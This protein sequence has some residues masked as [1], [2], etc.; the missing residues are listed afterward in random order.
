MSFSDLGAKIGV[1]SFPATFSPS[2]ERQFA[3]QLIP[4]DLGPRIKA[5][6]QAGHRCSITSRHIKTV[7]TAVPMTGVSLATSSLS[8][9]AMAW[10]ANG[11]WGA[12]RALLQVSSGFLYPARLSCQH[13]QDA[14]VTV[15]AVGA[16]ADGTT[17]PV[18]L[19]GGSVGA[20]TTDDAWTLQSASV[21]SVAITDLQG[22]DLDF[23]FQIRTKGGNSVP[24]PT[25]VGYSQQIPTFTITTGNL[26]LID[27]F[28]AFVGSGDVSFVLRQ[29]ANHGIFGTATITIGGTGVVGVS[30]FGG[31]PSTMAIVVEAEYDGTNNPVTYAYVEGM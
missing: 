20:I 3:G 11:S 9:A 6:M 19:G 25:E 4:G 28:S 23:G 13:Q 26:A 22:V 30:S 24:W 27:S 16:S 7:L 2:F 5:L 29:R 8:L 12:Q 15:E 10:A 1:A 21:A 18:I 31:D 14:Q 17:S